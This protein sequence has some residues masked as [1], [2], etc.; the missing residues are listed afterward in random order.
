MIELERISRVQHTDR[1]LLRSS[2][3]SC[4]QRVL[5]RMVYPP[6]ANPSNILHVCMCVYVLIVSVYEVRP[7]HTVVFVLEVVQQQSS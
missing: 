4:K 2:R 6:G 7:R 1:Q 5:A 3:M